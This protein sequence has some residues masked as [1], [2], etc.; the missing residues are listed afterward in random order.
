MLEFYSYK[1]MNWNQLQ[2]LIVT[3]FKHDM[4]S[5]KIKIESKQDLK[6]AVGSMSWYVFLYKQERILQDAKLKNSTF[7]LPTLR[8]QYNCCCCCCVFIFVLFIFFFLRKSCLSTNSVH[9]DLSEIRIYV[10]I[11]D[12]ERIFSLKNMLNFY[13]VTFH[14]SGLNTFSYD[15]KNL[16]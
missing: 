10:L 15:L 13:L 14:R 5:K 3:C 2:L 11:H 8:D 9:T 7:L 12:V 6:P 16:S 4:R 1:R